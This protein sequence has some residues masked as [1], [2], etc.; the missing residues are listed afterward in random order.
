MPNDS[1]IPDPGILVFDDFDNGLDGVN[2]AGAFPNWKFNDF[3]TTFGDADI[4]TSATG[5]TPYSGSNMLR[6][7]TTATDGY[8]SMDTDFNPWNVSGTNQ[9]SY[10]AHER[11]QGGTYYT[12]TY[13]ALEFFIRTDS[14]YTTPV[15]QQNGSAQLSFGT[16]L[17]AESQRGLNN[18]EGHG[19]HGY[20]SL[21]MPNTNG[22]WMKVKL[23]RAS[24]WRGTDFIPAA[25]C[26]VS[27]ANGTAFIQGETISCSPSG[28]QLRYTNE[29]NPWGGTGN[30]EVWGLWKSYGVI[31]AAGDT[32]TG[33]TSGASRTIS[34]A[35]QFQ[36]GAYSGGT[37]HDVCGEWAGFDDHWLRSGCTHDWYLESGAATYW[38]RVTRFYIE[39]V[40]EPTGSSVPIVN[41]VD[42]LQWSDDDR[43]DMIAV[44]NL[45]AFYDPSVGKLY[46]A[47]QI[48][49]DQDYKTWEIRT[50]Y[51][52][53]HTNGL[54]SATVW[55]TVTAND[56]GSPCLA[57]YE[58]ISDPGGQPLYISIRNTDRSTFTQIKIETA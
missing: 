40:D 1:I 2:G 57:A 10:Y 27:S 7:T 26:T 58:T 49:T 47:W 50:S 34:A 23:L 3:G 31:P 25:M 13:W 41:Y 52:D 53:I 37:N 45:A 14:R 39:V 17:M 9:G 38:D 20:H 16:Y 56:T 8:V 44:S 48:N 30:R 32:L 11:T 12:N 54:A 42:R 55:T 46:V 19:N 51:N 33:L 35:I 21:R 36:P 15:T 5:V 29:I 18:Q 22:R 28:A 6:L 4:V 24:Q 43:D